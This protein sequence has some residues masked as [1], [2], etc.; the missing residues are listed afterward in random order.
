MMTCTDILR[1]GTALLEQAVGDCDPRRE[2]R[3]LLASS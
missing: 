1:Q 2:A 3:I